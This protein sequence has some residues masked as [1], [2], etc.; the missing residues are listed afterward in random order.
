M[1][2]MT[3]FYG[4]N[5][6]IKAIGKHQVKALDFAYRFPCWHT[7]SQDKATKR[8]ILA[9]AKKGYF[10]VIGDQFRFT[11]PKAQNV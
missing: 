7:Y 11:Y 4:A 9:L 1:A 10:E 5:K 2:T 8:A 6:P 3:I